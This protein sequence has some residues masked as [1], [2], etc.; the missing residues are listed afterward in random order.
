MRGTSSVNEKTIFQ[1]LGWR[2]REFSIYWGNLKRSFAIIMVMQS[3]AKW[4][5][6]LD[7]IHVVHT[8]STI[9]NTHISNLKNLENE[10][11]LFGIEVWLKRYW[12]NSHIFSLLQCIMNVRKLQTYCCCI[13]NLFCF[14]Y[15]WFFAHNV[16]KI[17]NGLKTRISYSTT[18]LNIKKIYIWKFRLP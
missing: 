13:L 9:Q 15:V 18:V 7:L 2:L 17:V 6:E 5:N 1:K 8:I 10:S 12:T 4:F 11:Q 3:V 16:Q 14:S